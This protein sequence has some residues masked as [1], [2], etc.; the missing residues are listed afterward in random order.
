MTPLAA[1]QADALDASVAALCQAS[2]VALGPAQQGQLVQY[3]GL[4][5]K[6]NRVYNLTA[7]REPDEMLRLHLAD[8]LAVV[9]HFGRELARQQVS[10]AA[11]SARVS[12]RAAIL[13]VGSGGGLP[14]VILAIALPQA[15]VTAC[16]AVAKKCAFL[17]QVKAELGL[18]NFEVHHARVET[19]EALA[20]QRERYA[21]ITSRAFS[22]LPLLVRLS[23]PLLQPGGAWLAM[24]GA[25]PQDEM[26][27]LQ[28]EHPHWQVTVQPVA[29]PGL[30]AQRCLVRIQ[31]DA[32]S[33]G[34]T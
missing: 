7:V 25:V 10:H 6:W 3:L 14:A 12:S 31:P 9:P 4:L 17:L 18:S 23:A 1:P 5:Q 27:A 32:A 22:E 8:C 26:S 34:S 30:H 11:Q 33:G 21:L 20:S 13:D 15:I 2:G 19:L 29:V 16:D 24:K 28:A